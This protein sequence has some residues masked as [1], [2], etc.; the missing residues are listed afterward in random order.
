MQQVRKQMETDNNGQTVIHWSSKDEFAISFLWTRLLCQFQMA[1]RLSC[2]ILA[3]C[4]TEQLLLYT[5][6]FD[7]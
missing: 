1:A 2:Y 5:I 3:A 4:V 7:V 6:N